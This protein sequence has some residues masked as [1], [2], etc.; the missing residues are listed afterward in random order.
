[1]H[2]CRYEELSDIAEKFKIRAVPLFYFFRRGEVLE[3]FATRERR[4]IASAINRH[5]G[6]DVLDP[7]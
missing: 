7:H 3:Q 1:V 2:A 5:A 4:R 6:Y